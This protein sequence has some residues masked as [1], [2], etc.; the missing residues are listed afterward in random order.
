MRT[1]FLV[2]LLFTLVGCASSGPTYQDA[3]KPE[4]SASAI[5][6]YRP[7]KFL[8]GAFDAQFTIDGNKTADLSGG[9]YTYF[10]VSEGCHHIHQFWS[11]YANFGKK[12]DLNLCTKAG[13]NYYVRLNGLNVATWTLNPVEKANA[14]S[15]ISNCTYIPSVASASS[16]QNK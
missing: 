14:L 8:L 10:Y 15:D 13:E 9:S 2:L 7:D 5:Y 6:I 16:K 1:L 11:Y 4:A 3:P 12:T